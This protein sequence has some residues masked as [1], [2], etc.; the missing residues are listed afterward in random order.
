MH[1]HDLSPEH[2]DRIIA[3]LHQPA[4]DRRDSV[5]PIAIIGIGC[6]FPG[7][8]DTPQA[9]WNLLCNG[10]DAIAEVP[11][12]RWDWKTFYDPDPRKPGKSRTY[13]GGFL[14]QIDQF[15]AQFFGISPREA[16]CLD[17][18]QRLLLEVAWEAMEDAGLVPEQLAG[19][20]TSVFVGGFTLDYKLL[21]FNGT[22]RNA[23]EAHTATGVVMTMLANRISYT[24]DFRGPSMALDTACSSSLVAV[25]LACSSLWSGESTMALVGGV[26]VM[27][28]PDFTIAESKGGFL[29]PTGESHAFDA[30]ANGYVRSEGAGMV[31]LKPLSQAQA[32][33]DPIY[34]VI[35]GSAVNQ[36]GHTNGITVPNGASQEVVMRTAYLKAGVA[37]ED[38]QYA[39]AHGTGTPV[40][41]PIEARALGSVLSSHRPANH[42]A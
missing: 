8:A 37:P 11:A 31:V 32:D 3:P 25:H 29:S 10:T 26:N 4:Q 34:A 30:S 33:N 24:Y 21:Q 12:D 40:G 17:P 1:K 13:R 28:G 22:N 20:N 7:G 42:P 27:I 2:E 6:R 15:D 39:E 23:L 18:Q 36:D 5:E 19:S 41:D 38:I 35:C 14:S 16:A 9:F